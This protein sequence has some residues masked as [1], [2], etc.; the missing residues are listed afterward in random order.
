M[1]IPL[2][3]RT[4]VR[5][6]ICKLIQTKLDE[7]KTIAA[8][9]GYSDM[10]IDSLIDFRIYNNMYRIPDVSS[11][12]CAIVYWDKTSFENGDIYENDGINTLIIDIFASGYADDKDTAETYASNR[13]DYLES[14]IYNILCSEKACIYSATQHLVSSFVLLDLDNVYQNEADNSAN[15]VYMGRFR[16]NVEIDEPTE[17][18]DIRRIKEIYVESQANNA[19]IDTFILIDERQK[20]Q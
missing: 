16:F 6:L 5:D 15:A 19:I 9:N 20:Q 13:Y 3:K 14:Q 1:L 12:P 2:M 7:Q 8:Q 10:E 11:M 17:Y 18:L 4:I